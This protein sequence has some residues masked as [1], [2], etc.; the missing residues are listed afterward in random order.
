M[1]G[2]TK[3][4]FSEVGIESLAQDKPVV[5]KIRN[6]DGTNTYTGVATRGRVAERLKEHL[7]GGSDA[8]PG[9]TTV[10]ITPKS[11]I[12][13]AREAEARSIKRSKPRHNKLGK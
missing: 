9:A 7:P 10:E 8:I 4:R 1:A 6:R 13:D 11:S 2:K 3:A 12:A 5:Y